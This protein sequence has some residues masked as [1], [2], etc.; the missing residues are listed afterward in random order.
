[1]DVQ[2]VEAYRGGMLRKLGLRSDTDVSDL[3]KQ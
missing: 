3:V 2:L 1:M